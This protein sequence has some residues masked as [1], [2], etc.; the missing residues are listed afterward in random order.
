MLFRFILVVC[1]FTSFYVPLLQ[2]QGHELKRNEIHMKYKAENVNY[3]LLLGE[4][5]YRYVM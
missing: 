2:A 4:D 1:S 3:Q 5:R